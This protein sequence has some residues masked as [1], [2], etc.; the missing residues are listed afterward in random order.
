[1]IRRIALVA[2]LA[3]AIEA[4]L[5]VASA[6][7]REITFGSPLTASFVSQPL[8]TVSTFANKLGISSP[9]TGTIVRWRIT[10]ASG[11]P[12]TLRVLTPGGGST[13]TGGAASAPETPASLA[14]QTYA[15]DIP[16]HEFQAIGLDDS[17]TTDD[18]GIAANS[19]EFDFWTPPLAD[20][21]TR[22]ASG[23]SL[24]EIGF[25][26]DVR[27]LP[28]INFVKPSIGTP[29]GGTKVVI[30][31]ANFIGTTAVDFGSVPARSF[32]VNSDY[33][34]TAVSPAQSAPHAVHIRI[35]N[36]A[37]S[38]VDVGQDQFGYDC[39]VPNIIGKTL[40]KAK[41]LLQQNGCALGKVKGRRRGKVKKQKPKAGFVS[42]AGG[43][44]NVTLK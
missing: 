26:A 27:P 22:A 19:N 21:T 29:G 16:I 40:T 24:G 43:K 33:N 31:G 30:E 38:A 8:N 20:D 14:T 1:M 11:G 18:I 25:N 9:V 41:K 32:T 34:I 39:V 28:A 17:N 42:V 23:S 3:L 12:F 35:F 44:V 7:A 10:D 5:A 13:F 37:E 15:T 6:H 4:G 36:P 2:G